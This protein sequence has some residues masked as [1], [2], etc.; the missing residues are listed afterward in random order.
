[1]QKIFIEMQKA[2]MYNIYMN[3]ANNLDIFDKGVRKWI[4]EKQSNP[5]V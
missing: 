1:M 5:L 3:C 2:T 4:I